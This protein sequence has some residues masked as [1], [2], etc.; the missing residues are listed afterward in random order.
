MPDERSE[1]AEDLNPTFVV[2][3]VCGRCGELKPV[4][5]F[6]PHKNTRDRLNTMC[7]PCG[8]QRTLAWM[9]ANPDRRHRSGRVTEGTDLARR[10]TQRY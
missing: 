5:L 1:F 9:R 10:S 3:K 2:A 8:V 7:K 6:G 4:T